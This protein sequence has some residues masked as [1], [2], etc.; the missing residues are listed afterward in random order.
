MYT[1]FKVVCA[2]WN[3]IIYGVTMPFNLILSLTIKTIAIFFVF[4]E[5][6]SD[7]SPR[8]AYKNYFLLGL[9]HPQLSLHNATL[10]KA[11]VRFPC[12]FK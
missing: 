1:G 10:C 12:L 7:Q 11:M 8:Y 3:I 4:A 2:D 6:G 9:S 5:N